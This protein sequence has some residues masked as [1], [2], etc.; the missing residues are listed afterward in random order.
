MSA[1][2]TTYQIRLRFKE[3]IKVKVKKVEIRFVF[4][5]LPYPSSGLTLF[6]LVPPCLQ[7][8]QDAPYG[9]VLLLTLLRVVVPALERVWMGLLGSSNL[10]PHPLAWAQD[11][12]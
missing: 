8:P 7:Q 3:T 4:A 5:P 2:V 11:A 12:C 9:W 1:D 10:V 6:F